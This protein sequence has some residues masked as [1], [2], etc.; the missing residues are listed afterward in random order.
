MAICSL[1]VVPAVHHERVAKP[2]NDGALRLA[3]P[4]CC[5]SEQRLNQKSSRIGRIPTFQQSAAC[6][7]RT[8][9]SPQCNPAGNVSVNSFRKPSEN[10]Q[11]EF[12]SVFKV[13]TWRDMSETETSSQLHLPVQDSF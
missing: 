4:L 1:T 11:V 5:E 8:S 3:E 9:P 7:G 2:L 10:V 6:S 12:S 13:S